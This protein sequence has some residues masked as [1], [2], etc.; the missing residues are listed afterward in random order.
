MH[1]S[2]AAFVEE[3]GEQHMP[4]THWLE[5]LQVPTRALRRTGE[6]ALDVPLGTWLHHRGL[7][8]DMDGVLTSD[9]R[10]AGLALGFEA[11]RAPG[12]GRCQPR[13]RH[14]LLLV[15]QTC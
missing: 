3:A 4:G 10:V 6:E 14:A 12:V 9:T 11:L 13:N 15:T 5:L 1:M 8:L 2:P 7:S